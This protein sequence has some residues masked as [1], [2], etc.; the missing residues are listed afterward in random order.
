MY[1]QKDASS[2]EARDLRKRGGRWLKDLRT[3]AGLT[4]RELAVALDLQYYTFISQLES[5][6]GRVPPN[7]IIPY[8]KAVGANPRE[9]ALQM[10]R[11]YDPFLFQALTYGS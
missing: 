4:Q 5:G 7:L 10:V 11:Y 3:Q 8:A 2:A 9:F 6:V 1:A